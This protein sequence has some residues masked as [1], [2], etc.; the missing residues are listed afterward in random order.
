MK[1]ILALL[2]TLAMFHCPIKAQ[3]NLNTLRCGVSSFYTAITPTTEK[4]I[5]KSCSVCFLD[6]YFS[7]YIPELGTKSY[8]LETFTMTKTISNSGVVTE[9]YFNEEDATVL[10]GDLQISIEYGH[11]EKTFLINYTKFGNAYIIV[12]KGFVGSADEGL[13]QIA[14]QT[15][16]I[17]KKNNHK[18]IKDSINHSAPDK[19]QFRMTSFHDAFDKKGH[20]I[21]FDTITVSGDTIKVRYSTDPYALVASVQKYVK[22][23]Y[24][25]RFGISKDQ[26]CWVLTA[27]PVLNEDGTIKDLKILGP[28]RPCYPELKN[29][30]IKLIQEGNFRWEITKETGIVHYEGTALSINL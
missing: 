3:N 5:N 17:A 19:K 24:E 20:R 14:K 1:N 30:I 21:G 27:V 22:Q 28:P 6:G 4:R 12:A 13:N 23:N 26:S 2:I 18:I 11:P 25:K 29:N 16:E 9:S 8:K 7:F 10:R 15:M